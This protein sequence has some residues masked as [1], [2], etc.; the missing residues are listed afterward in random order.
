MRRAL[1]RPSVTPSYGIVLAAMVVP[2]VLG[3]AVA[4]PPPVATV[5]DTVLTR[6]DLERV[7]RRPGYPRVPG[8]D[9][10]PETRAKALLQ[11]VNE[12][13]LA[14]EIERRGIVVGD[15]DVD[16]RLAAIVQGLSARKSSL[17]Q[18]LAT[19]GL[20]RDGLRRQVRFEAGLQRLALALRTPELVEEIARSRRR[21]FDG[22]RLRVSHIILRPDGS[23]GDDPLGALL[24]RARSIREAIES[25]ATTFAAAAAAHSAGPSRHRGGD[26][27]FIPRHGECVEEFA[28]ACFRQEPGTV[29]EPFRSP[30]GVHIVTVTEVDEGDLA[31]ERYRAQIETLAADIALGRLL[32][33]LRRTTTV[34][35]EPGFEMARPRDPA[36][37]P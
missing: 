32:E 8:R 2:W 4:D 5:G 27:G 29:S 14:A 24:P 13:L 19:T 33:D 9:P 25:G 35:L 30:L 15:R 18:L 17:D 34:T 26:I 31:P 11:L 21:E 12:T 20:D 6:A 23:Q 22:T 3:A 1:S 16:D 28:R 37:L 36:D 7:E 10:A